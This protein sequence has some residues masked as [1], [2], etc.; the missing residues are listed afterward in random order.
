MRA[1]RAHELGEPRDVLRLEEVPEPLAGPGEIL[2]DVEAV[3]LNFPDNLWLAGK[4]QVK[5]P[6]PLTPGVEL[7]GRVREAG[8]AALVATG[9]RVVSLLYE[10]AGALAETIAVPDSLVFP[11]PESINPVDAAALFTIYMTGYLGLHRR[12]GLQ[13]GEVLLVHAGAGGVGSAAIQLGKAAGARVI[14]TAGGPEKVA[15]CREL[16]ADRAID[17]LSEDFVQIVKDETGGR[18]ADVIYDPVGGDI[19]DRSR[20]CIAWE[21][22][23][24]VVGFTGGR[25]AEAPTNHILLKNY[26]VVGVYAGDYLKQNRPLWDECVAALIR[27][28]EEGKIRPLVRDRVPFTEVPEGLIRL[29]QRQTVGKVVVEVR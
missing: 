8:D 22:R 5:P 20:R 21:G 6:L 11:V 10:R 26:S 2:I 14:A 19:F 15:I 28:Y 17:Y 29:S 4:Y 1:W 9:Q 16:G 3:G 27:L 25:I 24:I 12:A 23:I 7:A 13:P 18:G